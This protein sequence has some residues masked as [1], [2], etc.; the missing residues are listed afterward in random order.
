MQSIEVVGNNTEIVTLAWYAIDPTKYPDR[1]AY[2]TDLLD[3]TIFLGASA[4]SDLTYHYRILDNRGNILLNWSDLFDSAVCMNGVCSETEITKDDLPNGQYKIEV[5]AT[6]EVGNDSEI[7]SKEFSIL[8]STVESLSVEFNVDAWV[9]ERGDCVVFNWD[10]SGSNV[11]NVTFDRSSYVLTAKDTRCPTTTSEYH[12][13]VV[14]QLGEVVHSESVVITVNEPLA[15]KTNTPK[16]KPTDT[17]KPEKPTIYLSVNARCRSGNSK[18]FPD[19]WFF[20]AGTSSEVIGTDGNG[21]Y[22][23]K[24]SDPR[25]RKTE[26]WIGV[27]EVRGNS[28]SIQVVE[29][30]PPQLQSFSNVSVNS[31]EIVISVW[32]N[33]SI[34]G[35]RIRLTLNNNVLF[36]D[37]TLTGSPYSLNVTLNPGANYLVVTALNVGSQPP[38]TV[39]VSISNVTSGS[40]EQTAAGLNAGASQ[41]IITAP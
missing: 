2:K 5:Y 21:W 18:D 12:F 8:G 34:D 25:T 35:D 28:S 13:E 30:P 20:D 4:F 26:C 19:V 37:Y 11:N 3:H 27:G 41:M 16:P 40:S 10:V 7:I 32:D 1:P 15:T 17:P 23:I 24:F 6:D 33:A 38:N 36:S 29:T 9:I 14:S 22:K 39:T 31:K